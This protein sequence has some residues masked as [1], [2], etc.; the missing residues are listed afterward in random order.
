LG[1]GDDLSSSPASQEAKMK[2][3][4]VM[5]REILVA[6][7]EQTVQQAARMMAD[8]DAGVL[9]VGENDRLVGMITDRD[10]AIRCVAQGNGP[11]AKIR[12][13]M[14]HDVKYCFIDQDLD[15]VTRNMAEIQVRR[16]PVLD[17]D[18]RLVGIVSLGDIATVGEAME[19][20][21][22]LSGISMPGGQHTQSG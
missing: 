17:R 19:A 16:L 2:V 8:I 7:P 11:D 13:V 1:A 3:S 9:P 14:S 12:D 15:E 5:T 20:G 21:E 6:N 22:A 4:E 18:K 10:I